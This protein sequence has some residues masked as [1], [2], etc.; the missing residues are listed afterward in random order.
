MFTTVVPFSAGG[1]TLDDETV[2][3]FGLLADAILSTFRWSG[4]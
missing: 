4:E 3:E 2:E 1:E